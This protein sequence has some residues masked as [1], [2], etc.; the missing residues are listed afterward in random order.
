MSRLTLIQTACA[1]ILLG[2]IITSCETVPFGEPRARTVLTEEEAA[3][4]FFEA[5]KSHNRLAA[6]RVASPEAIN[7]LNW[8][9][10]AGIGATLELQET[11]RGDWV[12]LYDGGF[13]ELVIR[14]D[15]HVG[16]KITD[17]RMNAD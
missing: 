13:M 2:S 6:S 11:D 7:K 17:V 14:G 9:P 15:G 16:H 5:Y 12:I 10:L 1:A 8:N 3:R 4:R